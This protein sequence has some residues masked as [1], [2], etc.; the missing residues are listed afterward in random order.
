MNAALNRQDTPPKPG[1]AVLVWRVEPGVGFRGQ[2]CSESL[3]GVWTHWDG[4]RTRECTA[5]YVH[6]DEKGKPVNKPDESDEEASQKNATAKTSCRG[7]AANHPLRWKGYLY[8]WNGVLREYGFLELTPAAAEELLRQAPK[9][10]ALRGLLLRVDRA[11]NSMKSR[12]VVELT[13][14]ATDLTTLPQPQDPEATLRK[15][16]GWPN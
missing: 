5:K 3:W 16:W 10:G 2:I 1:P 15:L 14:S 13:K 11:G 6:V 9:D 8:V 4:Y 12:L 7:H